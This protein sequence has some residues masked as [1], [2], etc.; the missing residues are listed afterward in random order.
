MVVGGVLSSWHSQCKTLPSA[1]VAKLEFFY[2]GGR[3][4][5]YPKISIEP[6]VEN[7]YTQK[8]LYE[9]YI[10]NTTGRKVRGGGWSGAP[11]GPIKAS[12]LISMIIQS[13]SRPEN[14]TKRNYIHII[15]N[16]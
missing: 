16:I 9:N 7:I 6:G 3:K 14:V 11:P 12:P 10:Y 2:E 15:L 5:I 8:F 1:S 13:Q 4:R